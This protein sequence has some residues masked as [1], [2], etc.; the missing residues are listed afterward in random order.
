MKVVGKTMPEPEVVVGDARYRP[1]TS[2][3]IKDSPDIPK[4]DFG[5][6]INHGRTLSAESKG[7]N[8]G[9][10][11]IIDRDEQFPH[12]LH[13]TLIGGDPRRQSMG[14]GA[15]LWGQNR[16]SSGSSGGSDGRESWSRPS[17]DSAHEKAGSHGSESGESKRRSVIWQP[18]MAQI[19]GGRSPDRRE[20][21]E[22]YVAEKAAAAA[23]QQQSR[24]RYVHQRKTSGTSPTSGRNPSAE[25]LP[26]PAS[27]GGEAAFASSGLASGTVD[28][29]NHLSAREQEY[30]AKQTGS[31]LLHLDNAKQKQ[32]P[33]RAG[34]LGA[35]EARELEKRKMRESW[36]QGGNFNSAAVQQAIAQRQ[37]QK[38]QQQ[39]GQRSQISPSPRGIGSQSPGFTQYSGAS[40]LPL[41]Q[42]QQAGHGYPQQPQQ[43][44][45]Y[46]QQQY[47]GRQPYEQPQYG[48]QAGQGGF[49]R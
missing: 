30:V 21:A 3:Q 44:Q 19:G 6:T 1:S 26:R 18:G 28:I 27:R 12:S 13:G 20:N 36:T 2:D 10:A 15:D 42:Q 48:Q 35:I 8:R 37:Q 23:A 14:L 25:H 5:M 40:Y 4:V 11:Q 47:Y 31:T 22:Q 9:N 38:Q 7:V 29:S 17:P 16:G 45:Q 41:Q 43:P 39:P 46:Q 33:H 49:A 32:P 24:S 34:L